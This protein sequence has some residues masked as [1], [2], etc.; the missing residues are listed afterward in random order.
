MVREI[1]GRDPSVHRMVLGYWAHTID[2]K[3]EQVADWEASWA[4]KAYNRNS[5]AERPELKAAGSIDQRH[6]PQVEKRYRHSS[7]GSHG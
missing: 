3:E 2:G 5:Q 6:L 4:Q 1:R 7:V